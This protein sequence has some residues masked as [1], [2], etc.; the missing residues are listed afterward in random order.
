[1]K[2]EQQKPQKTHKNQSSASEHGGENCILEKESV[3]GS[4]ETCGAGWVWGLLLSPPEL[5]IEVNP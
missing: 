1:M 4:T 5:Q 3:Q 2:K